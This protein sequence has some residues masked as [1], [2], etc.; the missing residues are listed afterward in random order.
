[1]Q[2]GRD[3]VRPDGCGFGD[4]Q[5]AERDHQLGD[6]LAHRDVHREVRVHGAV[7]IELRPRRFRERAGGDAL[8]VGCPGGIVSRSS[9]AMFVRDCEVPPYSCSDPYTKRDVSRSSK[10]V[11]CRAIS[12]RF[13][14][15]RVQRRVSDVLD[16]EAVEVTA[17][18][19]GLE[20]E[21]P[22]PQRRRRHE[23]AAFEV[24]HASA[25]LTGGIFSSRSGLRSMSVR[26]ASICRAGA[27]SSNAESH[28]R[29]LP[30]SVR[31][32]TSSPGSGADDRRRWASFPA[33]GA[34]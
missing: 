19:V 23:V 20:L 27:R 14:E 13:A 33:L 30:A 2:Q 34:G 24:R 26:R 12:S 21:R 29:D 9:R 3:A 11:I 31:R 8:G 18:Q 17:D 7:P 4:E 28:P 5:P 15:Q 10:A 32:H 22:E 1:M 25:A 16:L 6:V